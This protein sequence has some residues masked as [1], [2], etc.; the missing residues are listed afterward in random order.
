MAFV[1]CVI[2]AVAIDKTQK[3]CS[4]RRNRMQP[5][6]IIISFIFEESCEIRQCAALSCLYFSERHF[7]LNVVIQVFFTIYFSKYKTDIS[8]RLG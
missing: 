8:G 7:Q 4:N 5:S 2:R 6:K 3:D 1:C